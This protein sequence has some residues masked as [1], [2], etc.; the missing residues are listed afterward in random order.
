[1]TTAL[2][3]RLHVTALKAQ[4]LKLHDLRLL[5]DDLHRK[6]RTSFCTLWMSGWDFGL[7]LKGIYME[8][9]AADIVSIDPSAEFILSEVEWTRDDKVMLRIL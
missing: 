9:A 8:S 3:R 6:S 1:M 7:P 4:Y 2:Q 5:F